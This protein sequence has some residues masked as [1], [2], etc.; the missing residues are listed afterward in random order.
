M[1]GINA[2]KIAELVAKPR[3]ALT[4]VSAFSLII[5]LLPMRF[6]YL[7]GYDPFFHLAYIRYAINHGWVNFYPYALGPWGI[8][9]KLFHPLGLWMAPA[10]VYKLL[11]PFGVSLF[12]AFRV[13][14]VIFGVLT[15]VLVY[16]IALRLYDGRRALL[17]AFLLAVSFGHVFRS[18]AGYYRGDNYM[19]FWY[20]VALLGIALGL[21]WEPKRWKHERFAL[22]LIPGIATGLSAIFW[23]AYYPIFAFVLANGVF[24]SLGAFLLGED[25]RILDGI[26]IVVSTGLGAVMANYLGGIFGY[27]MVGYNRW[28]GR[29]IAERLGIDFGFIKDA[30]LLVH[31]KYVLPLAV[32]FGAV[33]LVG[34]RFLH[35]RGRFFLGVALLGIAL[36]A[37]QLREL[38]VEVFNTLFYSAPITET[39]RTGLNDLWTAYG[40][41]FLAAPVFA[42]S[43]RRKRLA[44]YVML[45]LALVAVPMLLIW[46]RFLFIGSLA[47]AVLAGVGLV[48]VYEALK[49]LAEPKKLGSIALL[50]LIASVPAT[51]AYVGFKN[52]LSVKPVVN[53]NWAVALE[54]LGNHSN[55]N[56]VVLTWWDQGHWV[57][58]FAERAPVAQGSPSKFVADYYL[59]KVSERALMNL[60]VDYVIVSL[61]TLLKFGSV[62]RTANESG[63]SL[64]VLPERGYRVFASGSYSVVLD[65]VRVT[66]GP[67]S[68]VPIALYV[69]GD[70]IE[71][72]RF[73]RP[74]VRAYVYVNLNYGYAVVVNEKAFDTPLVKLMFTNDLENY[75]LL[76][77]D[78]G[79][80]KVFRFVHPNVVVT[81]QNGSTV[82]E[83]ENATGTSLG[84]FG[85]LD[86]GTLVFRKWYPV[87][88]LEKFSLPGDLNGSVVVRYTYS[89]GTVLDRGVFRLD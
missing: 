65:P 75:R 67:V 71:E 52:T 8:Q 45:G 32:V 70:G 35:R 48:D 49:P 88:G 46:T 73:E 33:L 78:G 59:G 50:I 89:N 36:A 40:P 16:L 39:Q 25:E 18:M 28:L 62:V 19:L 6:E 60:G 15:V 61:D 31:L 29:L 23:Q 5:R 9:V 84:I 7:L 47:I 66:L 11:S 21:T 41:A 1:E 85:F 72:Y 57:T 3:I 20:G 17:S 2:E 24:L 80:V 79:I 58:Y 12:N 43:L 34:S 81:A 74:T 42:L 38:A 30:F 10:F 68:G 83:F 55:P 82:L 69:E 14:P 26:A 56:D 63:Y 86:N 13:T 76:Y 53:D 37:L 64:V 87:S 4:L 44:D 27:G 22:Y 54:Y 51:T 77:T